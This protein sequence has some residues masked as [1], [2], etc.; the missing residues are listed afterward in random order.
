MLDACR[1]KLQ[2]LTFSGDITAEVLDGDAIT[3]D[4]SS[5]LLNG[6]RVGRQRGETL[7]G[8]DDISIRIKKIGGKSDQSGDTLLT[9]HILS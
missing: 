7:T 9:L 8:L 2:V 6:R 4:E 5:I 3:L 1:K